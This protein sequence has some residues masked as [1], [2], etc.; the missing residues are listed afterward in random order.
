MSG[1]QLKQQ[2]QIPIGIQGKKLLLHLILLVVTVASFFPFYWL[3]VMATNET[4]DIFSYPP[5]LTLGRHLLENAGNVFK[6]IQFFAAFGNTL[7]IAVVETTLVLFF[8][9]LAGFT[10]AK[11]TFRGRNILFIVLLVTMMIPSQLSAVP[12]FVLMARLGW[13]GSFKAL[14]IPGMV[15]AFGVFWMR[16]YAESSVPGELVDAG[17]ID[18]CGHLRLYWHVAL[19]I[20]RPALAFLGIF[21]FIHAWNDYMWPL[22]ILNDP[23]KYTLQVALAQLD[24]VYGADYGMLMA[25][26]LMATVPLIV[27]FL[28]GSRHFIANI[29]TGALKE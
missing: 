22:I 14:I 29:A 7:F 23:A 6:N 5:K 21:S 1:F 25:G 26:T 20:M 8:C 27:I 4:S 10:F 18:G 24:N 9:S 12:S 16:Q 2:S 28:L 15:T 11:F 19:P 3:I 17:R 13:V